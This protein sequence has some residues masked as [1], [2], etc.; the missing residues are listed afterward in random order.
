MNTWAMWRDR[1]TGRN[2]AP[3]SSG[4]RAF[5]EYRQE[6]L[7]RLEEEQQEFAAYLDRLRVAKDKAEFDQ[8]MA[9]RWQ[10]PTAPPP[11]Q[12]SQPSTGHPG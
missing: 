11:E 9:E 8:F 1:Y 12:P 7:R 6:T 4:N 3:P 2:N 10:R 5:D